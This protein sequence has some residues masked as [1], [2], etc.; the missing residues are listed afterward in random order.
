MNEMDGIVVGE[1]GTI[2]R[3]YLSMQ[4]WIGAT[5][6]PDW[7]VDL[8]AV[9]LGLGIILVIAAIGYYIAR[10]V[11]IRV[12]TIF[13]RKTKNTW[14][15]KILDRGVIQK[16][17]HVVPAGLIYL[18]ATLIFPANHRLLIIFLHML[19]SV[20]AVAMVLMAANAF[21]NAV[22][23]IYRT[24]PISKTRPILPYIQLVKIVVFFFG[25]VLIV[26]VLVRES[27]LKLLFGLSAVGAMFMFVFKDS[28]LGLVAS[29]LVSANDM[30]KPDD[31]ISMPSRN[32]DGVV[33][34]IT[35]N[36]VK[37]QNWDRTIVTFPTYALMYDSCINWKGMTESEGRRIT[38]NLNIDVRSVHICSEEELDYLE[39]I[40]LISDYVR[41]SREEYRVL[42]EREGF[43]PS[44]VV[45]GHRLSN[46]GI[47]RQYVAEYLRHSDFVD[48][49]G[50]LMARM[51]EPTTQGLPI[52][53]YCFSKI[54]DWVQYEEVKGQIFDH[55]Y[56]VLPA[57]NLVAFQELGGNDLKGMGAIGPKA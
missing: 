20:Y 52:Q 36:T 5:G 24:Y 45:N 28:I 47:F 26:A 14:D 4:G 27:P 7:I 16:L 32:A 33:L 53:V 23:D 11:V 42:S 43:D 8:L 13:A 41:K 22:H 10:A 3:W 37:V 51:L 39:R 55:L 44:V 57:F 18:S 34:E 15:D 19:A 2:N 1:M 31:W 48:S 49:T 56:S 50:T 17:C 30:V 9:F 54:K 21:L 46:V 38:R 29:I 35:L 12:F 40:D 25:G 6:M